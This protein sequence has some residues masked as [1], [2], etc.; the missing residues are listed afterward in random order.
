[1]PIRIRPYR[2]CSEQ[3]EETFGRHGAA[4]IARTY[5]RTHGWG[6]TEYGNDPTAGPGP[7]C[8]R[9]AAGTRIE[10]PDSHGLPRAVAA[11]SAYGPLQPLE[12]QV[13]DM[14]ILMTDGFFEW[15]GPND[16]QFGTARLA[17]VLRQAAA[18]PS[19]EIIQAA[20]D[21]VLAHAGGSPQ[22][23]DLTAVVIRRVR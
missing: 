16:K 22:Q 12:M 6:V 20:Y 7:L 17:E 23:D 11:N 19:A 18:R 3:G 10:S 9:P 13:G 1:M 2:A 5:A 15:L 14:L 21:A 8:H 4:P